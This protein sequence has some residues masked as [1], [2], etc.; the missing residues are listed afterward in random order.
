MESTHKKWNI[1]VV[2][3]NEDILLSLRLLLQ[4]Y[5]NT[6]RTTPKPE[7]IPAFLKAENFDLILL[8]MNFTRDAIS[9]TE[10]FHWIEE[11][12]KLDANAAIICITAYG[13]TEKA[14]QAIKAGATDF[15]LKPWNNDKLIATISSAI[16]LRYS[17]LETT[18]LRSK[19]EEL[20]TAQHNA[21]DEFLGKST[22]MENV[23][24]MIA[25]VANTDASILILGENGTGKELV[26]RSIHKLS[27]RKNEIFVSVDLGALNENL[28]ESELFGYVKG[29][30]TDAKKDKAGKFEVAQGGTIFLD[31][32]GNLSPAMQSKLLTIL[33]RKE[34]TRV[35]SHRA[36]S[37]DVRIVCATNAKIDE[38]IANGNFRED[39]YY[40]INTVELHLP[41]LRDRGTDISMLTQHFIEKFATK[42]NK[43]I[44]SISPE[45]FRKLQKHNWPGNVRELRHVM[46]RTIIMAP[47]E[48]LNANDFLL[49]APAQ[50]PNQSTI[51]NFNLDEV[52]KS[53]IERVMKIYSGNISKVAKEL[54]LSRAALYRRMEKHNL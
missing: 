33:E 13:D 46:E 11:I 10:G 6:I 4:P 42:Y 32:I 22:S 25:Q 54:G 21:F 36:I 27:D 1:L 15:V 26:A 23:F 41:P 40:R 2:D 30:F 9:G 52:E 35:G 43:T 20:T 34:V 17:K 38:L 51:D 5:T 18:L 53:I 28:F 39:L 24:S 48:N 31:E 3:D 16:R 45:A 14:V 47:N 29:A 8:D 19:Q 12:M 7:Q 37:L 50:K 44:T 49:K